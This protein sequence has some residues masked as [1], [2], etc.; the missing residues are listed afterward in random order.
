MRR[1]GHNRTAVV[2]ISLIVLVVALV[3]GV[4]LATSGSEEPAADTTPSTS[5]TPTPSSAQTTDVVVPVYFLGASAAGQRLFRTS[6][7]YEAP[8]DTATS[9]EGRLQA[10]VAGAVAGDSTDSSRT[11]AFPD[12]TQAKVTRE[13]GDVTVD[14]TGTDLEASGDSGTPEAGALALQSVVWTVDAVLGEDT[15]VTFTVGGAAV[16]SVLGADTSTAVTKGDELSTLGLVQVD[17]PGPDAVSSPFTVSGRAAA[18]EAALTWRLE[19]Q[20]GS[21]VQQG[22]ATTQECCTFSPYTFEVTAPPGRYTLSVSDG[23]A[24]GGGEGGGPTTDSRTVT[25]S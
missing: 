5:P 11:S 20:D 14:L 10:A 13:N 4:R 23:D 2:V 25:V 3:V 22:T 8:A 9:V 17:S 19:S 21:V 15:P 6:Q 1:V 12:E 16:D 7:R 24:S 18:N